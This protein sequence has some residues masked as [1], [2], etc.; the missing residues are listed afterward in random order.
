MINAKTVGTPM[1]L[2]V[3]FVLDHGEPYFDPGRCRS[4]VGKLN[5][6]TVTCLDIAFCSEH[7]KSIFKLCLSIPFG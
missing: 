7:S 4:F 3:K 1:D 6:L 5:N 2:S